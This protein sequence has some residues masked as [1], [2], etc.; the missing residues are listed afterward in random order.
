MNSEYWGSYFY[1]YN[2]KGDKIDTFWAKLI[3]EGADLT[4]P[5]LSALSKQSI[6]HKYTVPD[7]EDHPT[8]HSASHRHAIPSYTI[9]YKDTARYPNY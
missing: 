5:C 8:P 9:Y 2:E 6:E 7:H 1:D 3:K 4:V